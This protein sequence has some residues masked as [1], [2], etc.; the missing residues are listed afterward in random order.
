MRQSDTENAPATRRRVGKWP[1]I[2]GALALGLIAGE[3]MLR[4]Q[5]SREAAELAEQRR[6]EMV[7]AME[8]RLARAAEANLAGGDLVDA[9]FQV[10]M[11]GPPD[12]QR[13]ILI[14]EQIVRVVDPLDGAVINADAN[15]PPR[16]FLV[17]LPFSGLSLLHEVLKSYGEV[18]FTKDNPEPE[19]AIGEAPGDQPALS[20]G[21]VEL[22]EPEFE[23]VPDLPG[24]S[25][26]ADPQPA[27]VPELPQDTEGQEE[28]V[29]VEVHLM[30]SS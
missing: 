20:L 10:R 2:L 1:I 3:M 22:A 23:P 6:E 14:R 13:A 30:T 5:R 29:F 17:S 11:P 16:E 24:A 15:D 12:A 7:Q 28:M 18:N 21:D 27:L 4:V 8:Q 25:E 26:E 19:P 9:R